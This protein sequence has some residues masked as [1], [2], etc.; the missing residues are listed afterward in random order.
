MTRTLF[1]LAVAC[2][3]AIALPACAAENAPRT[4]D[5]IVGQAKVQK[6]AGGFKFT[7]G[8][9]W[10]YRSLL[11]FSDIPNN[12]IVQLKDGK[13]SVYRDD[14]GGANGLMFDAKGR[15]VACEGSARRI[16]RQ[17]E[18]GKWETLADSY[19]GKK[20][21]SPNDLAI[22]TAGRVYFTDPRYGKGSGP[23]EQDREAVYRID[24]EG[25]VTRIIDDCKKPNGIAISPDGKTLYV[26]DN[27]AGVTRAY[28]LAADGS[29]GAGKTICESRG[30]DGMAVD[31]AGNLY[32]TTGKGILVTDPAGKELG[33]IPVPEAPANCCFGGPKVTTLYITAR[34]GLYKIELAARGWQVQIDGIRK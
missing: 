26:V 16:A 17:S 12:H 3:V 6:V 27:G 4:F 23:V 19:N 11:V 1:T 30:G 7:E 32:I 20:L 15:L 21:N 33:V 10:D 24:P 2:S 28:P 18:P 14:S 31:S 5:Q 9:A 25:K 22:D 29:V 8:P 13:T 34:T